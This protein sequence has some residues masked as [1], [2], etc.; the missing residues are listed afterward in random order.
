VS[1][2]PSTKYAL[3]LKNKFPKIKPCIDEVRSQ[4]STFVSI[5]IELPGVDE[6]IRDCPIYFIYEKSAVYQGHWDNGEPH[7]YGRV[8]YSD[9]SYYEGLFSHSEPCTFITPEHHEDSIYIFPDG[10]YYRGEFMNSKFSGKGV[11]I[12]ENCMK[13]SGH[14]K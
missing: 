5:T 4:I 13:I 10:T 6:I 11:L 3:R 14:F 1:N 2:A 7:G 8:V 9:F 12:K